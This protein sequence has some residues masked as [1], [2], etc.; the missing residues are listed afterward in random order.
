MRTI[1]VAFSILFLINAN[2]ES[3][4][5]DKLGSFDLSPDGKQIVFA[6]TK[7]QTSA[8]YS[9]SIDGSNLK[10]I[11]D[12]T[13][14]NFANPRYSKNG[15]TIIYI[16]YKNKAIHGALYK[17][18]IQNG[19]QELLTDTN[20]TITE[21]IFSRDGASVFFCKANEYAAY[22]ILGRKAPHNV[23]IYSVNLKD[24]KIARISNLKAYGIGSI[25]DFDDSTLMMRSDIGNDNIDG[26]VLLS[27]K[28]GTVLKRIVPANDPRKYASVYYIPTYSDKFKTL[29]F[30]APLE[31]FVMKM[32]DRIAETVLFNKGGPDIPILRAFR[33]EKKILFSVDDNNNLFTINFDGT[34]LRKIPIE[35][36]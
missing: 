8:I 5:K 14:Y 19:F 11:I 18:N 31:I 3:H 23:D 32:E 7:N 36:K 15:E 35:I 25:S 6:Y 9:I 20:Q 2:I 27:K 17:Y 1:L 26:I 22:S 33:D 30:A 28:T 29:V 4:S 34:D 21:A 13:G 16:V 12:S 24:K 10:K